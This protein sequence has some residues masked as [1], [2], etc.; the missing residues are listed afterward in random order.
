MR[1]ICTMCSHLKRIHG[2]WTIKKI[3]NY[4]AKITSLIKKNDSKSDHT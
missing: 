3:K 1:E 2:E 4:L